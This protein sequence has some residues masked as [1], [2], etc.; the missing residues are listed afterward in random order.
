MTVDMILITVIF[1]VVYHSSLTFRAR[2]LKLDSGF[3]SHGE[4]DFKEL[5]S[6]SL[7]PSWFRKRLARFPSRTSP[8]RET[9]DSI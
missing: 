6:P 2:S 4:C 3:Y 1:K 5:R 7:S 8:E 9:I